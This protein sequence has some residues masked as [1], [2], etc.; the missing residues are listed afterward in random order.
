[1]FGLGNFYTA[2]AERKL[3]ADGVYYVR[4]G[5]GNLDKLVPEDPDPTVRADFQGNDDHPAYS[6]AQISEALL[7]DEMA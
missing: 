6:D 5:Y 1:M 3:P 4:G 2:V 7:A